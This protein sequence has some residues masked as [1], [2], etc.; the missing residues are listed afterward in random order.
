MNIAPPR[1]DTEHASLGRYVSFLYG[2]FIRPRSSDVDDAR[3]E[4]IVN[5]ILFGSLCLLTLF[6]AFLIYSHFS[7]SRAVASQNTSPYI[8]S[9]IYLLFIGLYLLSRKGCFN[10]VS[11]ILTVL[12]VLGTTYAAWQ[13]GPDL[14]QVVLSYALIVVMAG[15]IVDSRWSFVITL[16]I[17]G[18]IIG[19]N[20]LSIEGIISFHTAWKNDVLQMNDVIELSVTYG[21]ICLIAW[22]S[23]RELENSLHRAQTAER[24]LEEKNQSLEQTILER[25]ATLRE[26]Q[27][28]KV[29]S[30]YHLAEFGRLSSGIFHDLIGA[31]SIVSMNVEHLE[32]ATGSNV[33]VLKEDIA[34]A[35]SASRRIESLIARGKKQISME[36][37]NEVFVLNEGVEESIALLKYKA[38]KGHVEIVLRANSKVRTYGSA[39]KFQQ[40]ITNLLSN[41]IDACD[42]P[43]ISKDRKM[44]EVTLEKVGATVRITIEDGGCGI[45]AEFLA[46]VFDPFFTTKSQYR[47]LGLGL[48]NTKQAVEKDFGGTIRVDSIHNHGSRFS[49][50]FPLKRHA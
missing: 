49:I 22:L 43:S 37:H 24:V 20:Y 6:E 33:T 34:R 11:Y 29:S 8:F 16:F 5:I 1:E 25:T 31:L 32:Q 15:I 36:T 47:G 17:A 45:P 12:Y 39:S 38:T 9:T 44:V 46:S 18:T 19:L 13:W 41:A 10:I 35:V 21:M 26:A 28:E 30:L 7:I 27:A 14:Y 42:D 23:N 4:M 2:A 3:R 40:I 50:T 48:S